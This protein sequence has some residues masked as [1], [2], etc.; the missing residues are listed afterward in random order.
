VKNVLNIPALYKQGGNRAFV[1]SKNSDRGA[2]SYERLPKGPRFA[3]ESL[4]ADTG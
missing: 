1:S 3:S 2:I 4:D